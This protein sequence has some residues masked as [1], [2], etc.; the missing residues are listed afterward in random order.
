[1]VLKHSPVTPKTGVRETRTSVL[2]VLEVL[3]SH[4]AHSPL[5][6]EV[7]GRSLKGSGESRR[8]GEKRTLKELNIE[9]TPV[10]RDEGW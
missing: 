1:M 5:T 9:E 6:V 3:R 4:S 10:L 8:G 7:P 2:S